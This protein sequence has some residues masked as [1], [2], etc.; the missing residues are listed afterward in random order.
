MKQRL[1][2]GWP[3]IM[4]L[5]VRF[6]VQ[7]NP[8]LQ[9]PDSA[10][11]RRLVA[12]RNTSIRTKLTVVIVMTTSAALL[13][14]GAVFLGYESLQSRR[15]LTS[16]ISA[17][18]E[19]V[20]ASNTAALSFGDSAASLE[21]LR[22]LH[23][24]QR[25]LRAVIYDKAG[26]PFASFATRNVNQTPGPDRLRPDGVYFENDALLLFHPI[27]LSTERIGSVLLVSSMSESRTRFKRYVGIV[28]LVLLASLL[29]S[30]LVMGR[31][32]RIIT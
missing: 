10:L 9:A 1:G 12:V 15:V 20:A 22:S 25:L 21:T 14:A 3:A 5:K 29:F 6:I 18:A 31:L 26:N 30:L 2:S 28:M 4:E 11:Q 32:Q 7:M 8:Q 16:E 19:I 13:M 27:K 23:G 24:D 17:L